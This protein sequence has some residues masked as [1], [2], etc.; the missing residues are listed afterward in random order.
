MKSL[1][2]NIKN[3]MPYLLLVAIYF[4]FINIE[5]KKKN[6]YDKIIEIENNKNLNESKI[7]KMDSLINIPVIPYKD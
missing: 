3:L 1:Y 6:N 4:F 7:K 2:I 5:A